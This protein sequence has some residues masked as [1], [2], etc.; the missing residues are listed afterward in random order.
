MKT[1][2]DKS[3]EPANRTPDAGHALQRNP[4]AKLLLIVA[5]SF[6]SYLFFSRVVVTAVEVRGSSMSPTLRP[7][8]RVMLNR[9]AILHRIP[10]R[11]ELVVLRDPQTSDLVVKR[12]VG[13]PNE[14]VQM[15]ID[16]AFVNGNRLS[17]PY[18]MLSAK[19]PVGQLGAPV[20]VPADHFFV[21]G[22][23]R[24]NSIDSREFGPVR[25]ENI[26]GVISL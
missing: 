17:E 24:H 4:W 20:P 23:N 7:G 1:V 5:L 9:L 10:Q 15:G 14:T 25:R 12:V 6:C 8:D 26:L 16:H 3:P 19:T 2:L 22:D 13:L 18:L 11:G 21:L